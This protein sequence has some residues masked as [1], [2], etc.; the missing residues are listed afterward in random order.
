MYNRNQTL[1]EFITNMEARNTP[2]ESKLDVIINLLMLALPELSEICPL[3][4]GTQ[5]NERLKKNLSAL[6]IQ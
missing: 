2:S 4:A 1:T 5:A 3:P 6:R